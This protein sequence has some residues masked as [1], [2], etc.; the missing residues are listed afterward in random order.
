VVVGRHLHIFEIFHSGSLVKFHDVVANP[1][2]SD[3][4]SGQHGARVKALPDLLSLLVV[5]HFV[6]SRTLS[7]VRYPRDGLH[8]FISCLL[9]SL[10]DLL[11]ISRYSSDLVRVSQLLAFKQFLQLS[12]FNVLYIFL[13]RSDWCATFTA[14]RHF[15]STHRAS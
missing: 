2:L 7:Q 3:H 12:S 4:P 8:A 15:Q 5:K 9:T 11:D 14:L 6:I 10:S 13:S 1:I